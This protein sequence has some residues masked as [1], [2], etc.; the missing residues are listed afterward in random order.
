MSYARLEAEDGLQ[1]PCYDETHPGELFLHGRLWERPI[2]GPRAPFAAVEHEPPVDELTA[3]FPIRLTTGRHLDSYNTGVQTG[4]Y[5]SPNR[6]P[7]GID[8]HPEDARRLGIDEGD[9]VRVVSRRGAV[10]APVR[11]DSG[12][13]PGLAFMTL[14]FPDQVATNELT[15]DAIDPLSGTSEFKATAVRIELVSRRDMAA[16]EAEEVPVPV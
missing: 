14:H 12:L 16:M 10:T 5:A 9:L 11:F 7:A 6:R 13:R 1:W 8:L 15:I 3:E 4:L 2:V